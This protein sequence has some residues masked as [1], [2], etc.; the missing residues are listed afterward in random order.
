MIKSVEMTPFRV[1]KALLT[2]DAG[3]AKGTATT[4]AVKAIKARCVICMTEDWLQT[5]DVIAGLHDE[6]PRTIALYS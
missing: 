3:A 1:A 6:A 2:R 5:Q 4:P